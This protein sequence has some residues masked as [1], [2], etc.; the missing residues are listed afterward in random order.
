MKKIENLVKLERPNLT[1][2]V[3]DIKV[4]FA[5]E[6]HSIVGVGEWQDV[7]GQQRIF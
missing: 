7:P 6:L 5:A 4:D 2:L 3:F 1:S